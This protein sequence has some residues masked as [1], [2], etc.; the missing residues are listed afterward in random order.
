MEQPSIDRKD[1]LGDYTFDNCQYLELCENVSKKKI[2]L[3]TV[4]PIAER[5]CELMNWDKSYAFNI[6]HYS[7]KLKI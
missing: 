1:S 4:Q 3:S 7:L 6:R 2:I 5:L